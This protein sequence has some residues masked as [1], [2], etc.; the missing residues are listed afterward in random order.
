MI[1]TLQRNGK[2]HYQWLSKWVY[3]GL[4]MVGIIT[5][6]MGYRSTLISAVVLG[7]GFIFVIFLS[8]HIEMLLVG[9]ILT[10]IVWG[11]FQTLAGSYASEICPVV[12]HVYLTTYI[13]ACWFVGHLI[14]SVTLPL[15]LNM[16]NESANKILF[17]LHYHCSYLF[18][19]SVTLMALQE[20]KN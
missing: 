2:H 3:I 11:A 18:S 7:M 12:L 10:G 20:M 19:S 5:E 6:I 13:N 15:T 16:T 17:A 4:W 9:E 1:I 14:A 8:V